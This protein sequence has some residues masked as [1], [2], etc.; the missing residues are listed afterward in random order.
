MDQK[1]QLIADWQSKHFNI[2]DLSQKYEISRPIIYKWI[3]RYEESGI[4]GL[5]MCN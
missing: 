3:R 2:T 5:R 4:E 1:V